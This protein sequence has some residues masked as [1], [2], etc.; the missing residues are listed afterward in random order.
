VPEAAVSGPVVMVGFSG[1]LCS[2]LASTMPPRSVV[3]VEDP[4]VIKKRGLDDLPAR[5]RLVAELVAVPYQELAPAAS[6]ALA[7]SKVAGVTDDTVMAV[8]PG[9]EYAV[10][11]A[12]ALAERLGL[13]G[14]GTAATAALS[15][16][17]CLRERTT[18]A[19]M[20]GPTWQELHS[21]PDAAAFVAR[22]GPAVVKPASRQAS[23]GVHLADTP[24]Q[25]A[26]A[27][28]ALAD[29]PGEDVFN[30]ASSRQRVL[31]EARL[32]GPE[33]STEAFVDSCEVVFC[34][35]TAKRIVDGPWPVELGHVVPAPLVA[36]EE[37]ALASAVTDLVAALGF[38]TGVLHAE[39]I[40]T[41]DGPVLVECA[42]RIPGDHILT[43][44][45]HAWGFDPYAAYLQL[46]RG[47]RP[48]LPARPRQ[49]AAVR[50]VTAQPGI[51]QQVPDPGLVAAALASP[52]VFDA[53]VDAAP[54]LPVG[55]L[56]SSW[57]RLGHVIATGP[58][59]AVAEQRAA[60]VAEQLRPRTA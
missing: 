40:V 55:P 32:R 8:I 30:D 39:W 7:A 3:V 13:P 11:A 26:Q 42:G 6:A 35:I 22:V 59:A 28:R 48:D 53:H 56:R 9:I 23:I 17:L 2:A 36:G 34:N 38:V 49:A 58:D 20:P 50:F 33:R 4:A 43:L 46:L 31:A 44:V 47:T 15:D 27:W 25:A 16:K 1:L 19:G 41:A 21:G 45:Q 52:G 54:G 60:E 5:V 18:A 14:A 24:E 29:L 37:A 57:D 10:P 12:A 51:V